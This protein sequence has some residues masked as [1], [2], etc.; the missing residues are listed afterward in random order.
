MSLFGWKRRRSRSWLDMPDE[1]ELEIPSDQELEYRRWRYKEARAMH[2]TIVEAK[3]F[4]DTDI[5][6]SRL[7]ELVAK[8]CPD[9]LLAKVLL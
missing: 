4:A 7:R 6:M 3:V 9:Q 8:G 1:T 5:P 2:L